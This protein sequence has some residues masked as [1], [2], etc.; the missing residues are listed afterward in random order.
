M[1]L[2]KYVS[3]VESKYSPT[4]ETSELLENLEETFLSTTWTSTTTDS[5]LQ[6]HTGVLP[7]AKGLIAYIY[8]LL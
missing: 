3:Y 8:Y 2:S 1:C 6:P 5:N 4:V 7:V